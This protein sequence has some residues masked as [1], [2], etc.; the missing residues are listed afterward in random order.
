[1]K[2]RPPWALRRAHCRKRS[3]G[4][5]EDRSGDCICICICR[6]LLILFFD[7]F[8]DFFFWQQRTEQ[9]CEVRR[10]IIRLGV[11]CPTGLDRA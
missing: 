1:M 8:F 7:C 2:P 9:A 6:Y 10:E 11:K 3:K 5:C 4:V